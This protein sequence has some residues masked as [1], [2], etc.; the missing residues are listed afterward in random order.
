MRGGMPGK[1]MTMGMEEAVVKTSTY[2]QAVHYR[3]WTGACTFRFSSKELT[4]F[5]SSC[6]YN[7]R[8]GHWTQCLDE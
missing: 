6:T 4:L 8:F 7:L 2:I 3:Y 5:I 1:G